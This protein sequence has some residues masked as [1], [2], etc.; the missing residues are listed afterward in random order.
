MKGLL[1]K[2]FKLMRR[3][4]VFFLL[5]LAGAILMAMFSPNSNFIIGYMV[6]ICSQFCISTISYDEY[7]NGNPFLFS[8]PITRKGYVL[9]KYVLGIIL[10]LASL[11]LAGTIVTVAS[12][13]KGSGSL[14][15]IGETCLVALPLLVLFLSVTLPLQLKFG[16][17]RGTVALACAVV[18]L[19]I[20][21]IT[22]VK[23][24][25]TLGF[26]MSYILNK[27]PIVGVG[28]CVV[29]VIAVIAIAMLISYKISLSIVTK[30]EF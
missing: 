10:G 3:Q 8:L 21:F 29:G 4:G 7:D 9:E 12:L 27:L 23:V 5:V 22:A 18:A 14:T 16:A 24:A 1:I 20:I 30:K 28:I 17:E 25:K 11:A 15:T 6:F 13:V 2:D 19:T 26:E